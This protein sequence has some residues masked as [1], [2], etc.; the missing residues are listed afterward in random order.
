MTDSLFV[1]CHLG[2][3]CGLLCVA[4]RR[5]ADQKLNAEDPEDARQPGIHP[6]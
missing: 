2:H 3:S 1:A 4:D 6:T 5:L